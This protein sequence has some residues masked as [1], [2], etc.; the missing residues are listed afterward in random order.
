MT[1]A[2]LVKAQTARLAGQAAEMAELGRSLTLHMECS[3][4]HLGLARDTIERI[5]KLEVEMAKTHG[6]L[7][8]LKERLYA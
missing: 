2:A 1:L 6:R 3:V 8:C 7:D 4:P 5:S